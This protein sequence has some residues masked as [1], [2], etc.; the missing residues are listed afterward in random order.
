MSCQIYVW[1]HPIQ[2]CDIKKTP[3]CYTSVICLSRE[4]SLHLVYI[5]CM[6]LMLI[7]SG[8]VTVILRSSEQ[9]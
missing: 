7:Y 6:D 1:Q 2:K 5:L 4:F 8:L 3:F 9:G